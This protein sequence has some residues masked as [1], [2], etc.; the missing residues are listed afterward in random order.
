VGREEWLVRSA[1]DVAID[2]AAAVL[3]SA[4]ALVDVLRLG[5]SASWPVWLLVLLSWGCTGAVAVRRFAPAGA[6]AAA[7]A[8]AVA[9]QLA[10]HDPRFTF[11]PY[12]V[13][14]TMYTLGRTELADRRH[15][16][17]AVLAL[18]LP[19][20]VVLVVASD[21]ALGNVVP[22][23]LLFA[24]IPYGVGVLLAR[25]ARDS[26]RLRCQIGLLVDERQLQQRAAAQEER[27]RIARELHDVVAHCLTEVVIQSGAARVV[28][29]RDP[30]AARAALET[31]AGSGRAALVE[32]RRMSEEVR[33][34]S[35]SRLLGLLGALDGGPVRVC[36]SWPAPRTLPPWTD[37]AAHR[38]VQESLTNAARHAPGTRVEVDVRLDADALH[39]A[40]RNGAARSSWPRGAGAGYG[41]VGMRERVAA[42]GGELQTGPT[43]DG[44]YLVRAQLPLAA[45]PARKTDGS[46]RR[47]PVL[48]NRVRDLLVP[49]LSLPLLVG[50]ALTSPHRGGPAWLVVPVVAAMSLA[51]LLRRRSPVAFLV[52]VGALSLLLT[53]GLTSRDYATLTGLYTVVVPAYA[54][55]SWSSNRRTVTAMVPWG[56]VATLVGE[57]QQAS[58]AGLVGP[59]MTAAAA[60]GIGTLVRSQRELRRGLVAS[61]A[62]VLAQTRTLEA[63]AV[64]GERERLA[65]LQQGSVAGLVGSIVDEAELARG[66]LEDDDPRFAAAVAEV[67]QRGRDAL[68][69]MRAVVGALRLAVPA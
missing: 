66:L 9:Y 23:F 20:F 19:G 46:P 2:V 38:L 35:D 32:L 41:L 21:Q 7:V 68:A 54:V 17:R 8:A 30:A 57:I 37:I 55:G 1:R 60:A 12:A 64:A 27:L 50:E 18:A 53:H 65:E 51:A 26:D 6:A 5:V 33:G 14:L 56:V 25:R 62:T 63:L 42:L 10:A 16:H 29:S 4:G 28:A 69:R 67:E 47:R 22:S 34:D 45:P 24:L 59:L 13:L 43:G 3:L 40:V 49:V 31:A 48:S 11:E 44:G 39:L 52:V 15:V 61:E 58:L 36:L